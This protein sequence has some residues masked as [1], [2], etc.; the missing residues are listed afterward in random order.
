MNPVCL[1]ASGICAIL[2]VGGSAVGGEVSSAW[3]QICQSFADAAS[4]MLVAFG[5]AFAKIPPVNLGS[6]GITSVYGLS[7]DI[8]APVAGLL[9]I[10]Q[11]IRTALTH[12]G[13][14]M[15]TA[16]TGLA[17]AT[18]AFL[19][20]LTIATAALAA[21]DSVTE[22]IVTDSFGSQK[23]L[24]ARLGELL[25][26][27]LVSG[28]PAGGSVDAVLLMVFGIVGILLVIVLWF[29]LLL[30]NAA[31]AVLIAT[32]PIAA[33]GLLSESTRAWWS[34]LVSTTIQLIILKPVIALVFA[35]GLSMT[36]KAT[37]IETLLSGM[38]ILLLAVFAWPAIARFFTFA[39]VQVGGSAGLGALLGF[40][41]GRSSGGSGGTAGIDPSQFSR[42]AEQQTM[43]G[44]DAAGGEGGGLSGAAASPG[45]GQGGGAGAAAGGAA[46]LAG[47]AVGIAIAGAKLGQQVVNSLTGH[48]EQMAGHAGIQGAN[49]NAQPAGSQYPRQSGSY[50]QPPA[51]GQPQDPGRPSTAQQPSERVEQPQPPVYDQEPG[52]DKPP[53]TDWHAGADRYDPPPLANGPSVDPPEDMGEG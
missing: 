9:I 45:G 18:L 29:E 28:G 37:D 20:T 46:G 13:S 39:S 35:V 47:G 36:G 52:Y 10:G 3:Q 7:L 24:A 16:L 53:V 19:L 40:V 49:P 2:H 50:R 11:V 4:D 43:A 27:V 6:S 32:S 21:A 8:A 22:A 30:R 26:S 41:A 33:A 25:G 44:M 34:K 5:Q 51:S 23:A 38:L 42:R 1:F 31:I 14:P 12:D 17:K 15:A 48:M